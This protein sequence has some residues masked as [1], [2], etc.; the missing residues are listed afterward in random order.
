MAYSNKNVIVGA[1]ALYISKFDST[2]AGW[3]EPISPIPTGEPKN[4][5]GP[6]LPTFVAGES[7]AKKGGAFETSPKWRAA[8]YTTDGI[9]VSYEPDY[10]EVTVDQALDSVKMFKQGMRVSVNTTLSEAT[11]ENL[12]LAWGQQTSTLSGDSSEGEDHVHISGG[13]L[14]DDP[15]ERSIA[16]VG[17]APRNLST[18][19]KKRERVYHLRRSLQV[20]SSAHS[21]SRTD[22][23]TF[24]VSFRCLPDD[25]PSLSGGNYGNIIQR[26]IS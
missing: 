8:G 1:A 22:A 16:F 9:E 14:G 23:T 13:A 18:D 4:Q 10:G 19:N 6:N 25:N 7:A 5:D 21:L 3:V 26:V 2:S 15:V 24:P 12:I 17:P 20:E 11:L